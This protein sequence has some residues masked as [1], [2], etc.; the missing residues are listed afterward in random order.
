M[1]DGSQSSR[2][3]PF[4]EVRYDNNFLTLTVAKSENLNDRLN[5][6]TLPNINLSNKFC[7]LDPNGNE[8]SQDNA[9]FSKSTYS[10]VKFSKNNDT[11]STIYEN[12]KM[13]KKSNNIHDN[14]KT[15]KETTTITNHNL[16]INII[17]K[18]QNI[19]TVKDKVLK[20][21]EIPNSPIV[22]QNSNLV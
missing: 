14:E 9:E 13:N 16:S 6:N 5:E 8:V 17:S 20:T 7:S 11:R 12:I 22:N 2:I 3:S 15:L 21:L 18:Q 1:N 19:Q 4:N 10:K